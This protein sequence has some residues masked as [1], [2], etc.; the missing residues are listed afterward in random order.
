MRAIIIMPTYNE[1][2]NLPAITQ[3]IFTAA[4]W[5]NILVVDDNSPD[6]TGEVADQLAAQDGRLRVLHRAGK[7]GLGTAYIAGFKLAI[8]HG[9]DRVFEMD[10]DFSHDPSYLP[11]FLRASDNAELVIGSR[12]IPGGSTPNWSRLRRFISGGGNTFARALLRL[13]VHD[14]TAG[15]RCYH[16][17]A[18]EAIDLDGIRAT[19]YA[20]QVELVYRVLR[21]GLRV[22]EI[23]ITFVDRRVGQSKMSRRIFIEG[24]QYVMRTRR[25]QGLLPRA[26]PGQV[27]VAPPESQPETVGASPR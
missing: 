13:P 17:T 18:L 22:T 1:R 2:D 21:A 6:G 8:E 4:P 14:C 16:R 11:A 9:F 12:Y 3:A 5:A 20:F 27:T 15:F 10:A 24:F 7:Q 19:G 25:Q 26:T 23:P